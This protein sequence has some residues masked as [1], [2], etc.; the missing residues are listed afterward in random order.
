MRH[1]EKDYQTPD[2]A[3]VRDLAN[4]HLAALPNY[5][6]DMSSTTVSVRH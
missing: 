3:A 1:R 4:A 2:G 6:A 5:K